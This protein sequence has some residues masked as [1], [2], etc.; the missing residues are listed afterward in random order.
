MMRQQVCPRAH[1][2][3]T[4]AGGRQR[5]ICVEVTDEAGGE[6]SSL[7]TL[8]MDEDGY[9]SFAAMEAIHGDFGAFPTFLIGLLEK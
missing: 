2:P 3:Q 9:R 1:A 5:V 6:L 8:A 7:H 4:S